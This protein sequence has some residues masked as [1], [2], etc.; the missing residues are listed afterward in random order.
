[1]MVGRVRVRD[2]GLLAVALFMATGDPVGHFAG[3]QS[4]PARVAPP[5]A[6]PRPPLNFTPPPT[7]PRATVPGGATTGSAP[8]ISSRTAFFPQTGGNLL[9]Y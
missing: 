8:N 9:T 3:A 1:M 7:A 5:A 4:G 2:L 6:A